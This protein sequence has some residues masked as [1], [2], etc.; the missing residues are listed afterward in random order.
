MKNLSDIQ[1]GLAVRTAR[2][3]SGWSAKQLA[4]A[5]GIS[6][7]ALSKIE[8][9]KQTLSF[10]HAYAICLALGIRV[11]HLVS[12][13]NELPKQAIE[14]VSLKE[15]FRA[16]LKRLEQLTIRTAISLQSGPDHEAPTPP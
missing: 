4:E 1:I 6:S 3:A 11:D 7:T 16:D 5:S 10:A 2:L 9:G 8:S 12:L 13:M 14:T 15:K